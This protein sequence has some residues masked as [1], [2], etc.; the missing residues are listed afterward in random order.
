VS[1]TWVNY[2]GCDSYY[3]VVADADNVYVG[4]HERWANN[5][6]ACDRAGTGAL[7]RPGMASLSPTTGLATSWNP[8]R[9][10]G[11]GANDMVITSAGL[12]V[13][14]DNFTDGLA[15]KCGGVTNKGGICFLPY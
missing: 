2:T 15:Q 14:S 10:L 12:W 8:T 13:A 7:S 4:G 6:F 1:H 5:P 3:A 11:H 9:S